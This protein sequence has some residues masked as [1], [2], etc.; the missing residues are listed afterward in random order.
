[1]NEI[2]KA[3]E[4]LDRI[5]NCC[6]EIDLHLPKEEQTGYGMLVDINIIR[7]ALVNQK[8]GHWIIVDDCEKFIAK[9][10]K[11]GRIEDSR[12]I[13]K[14]PYCHCGAKMEGEW[15]DKC[16]KEYNAKVITRGNCMMCGKELT[17]GL[18]FCKKCEDKANSR[19]REIK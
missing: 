16:D 14:Y 19:K 6:E 4:A 8:T 2:T 1:M 7:E 11:C 18:F 17:E 13:S 10:S 15:E 9:C 12:M 5:F 3:L